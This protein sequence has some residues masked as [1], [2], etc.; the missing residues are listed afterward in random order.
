MVLPYCCL[1]A[2]QERLW[3][4]VIENVVQDHAHDVTVIIFA[5][6]EIYYKQL[7]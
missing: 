3:K 5:T 6:F 4:S 1:I 7:S 2:A